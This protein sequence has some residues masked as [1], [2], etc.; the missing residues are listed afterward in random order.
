MDSAH[1]VVSSDAE[2]LVRIALLAAGAAP[3]LREVSD[4]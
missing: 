4:S 3:G 1:R 2:Q